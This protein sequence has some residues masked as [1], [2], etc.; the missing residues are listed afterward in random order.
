MSHGDDLVSTRTE[1]WYRLA[2]AGRTEAE[3][4]ERVRAVRDLYKR[5]HMD[6]VLT[7]GQ[8]SLV[9]E[10]VPGEPVASHRVPA[11]A[12]DALLRRRPAAGVDPARRPARSADRHHRLLSVRRPVMFD[13]PLLDRGEEGLRAGADRRPAGRR[14]VRAGGGDL[15]PGRPPRDPDRD[16][17]PVRP[18]GR[19][20]RHAGAEGVRRAH[21]PGQGAG[22]ARCRRGRWCRS[23]SRGTST[24]RSSTTRRS[25]RPGPSARRW[26]STSPGCCCRRRSTTTRTPSRCCCG[27]SARSAPSRDRNYWAVIWRLRE[28]AGLRFDGTA[29]GRTSAAKRLRDEAA[30]MHAQTLGDLLADTAETRQGR[31]FFPP[32]TPHGQELAAP[33]AAHRGG[34]HRHHDERAGAAEPVGA[35]RALVVH[36][37]DERAGAAPGVLVRHPRRST[38]CPGTSA[39][40]WPWT[41]ATSWPCGRSGGR[42]SSGSAGT[43]ASTTCAAWPRPRTRRTR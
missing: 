11:A 21:R 36:R 14:Q 16:A 12:A 5:R 4:M 6:A 28:Y 13:T 40:C 39:R 29:D 17:R 15:L 18:A 8:A 42:C 22:R 33:A 24:R 25:T 41:S 3:C 20:V 43:P 38:A 37:A 2:V 23:R 32:L 1:G 19:A 26:P 9:R 10:F 27:R 30:A 34:A 35:A 7:K 31:L